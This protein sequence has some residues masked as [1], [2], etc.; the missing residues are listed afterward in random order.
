[1]SQQII[2][3]GAEANDG[4]GEP[5]RSAFN[6]VN[7]N[8]S[9][10]YAAGPVGSNVKITGNTITVTGI[11]NNL[12][13]AANGIGNIQANSSF[14]PS[15]SGVYSLGANGAQFDSVYSV[16]FYGNGA[17]LTGVSVDAGN[18]ILNGNSNV[19]I[20]GENAN[21][22]VS[23]NAVSNIAVFSTSG[24]TVSSNINVGRLNANTISVSG[25]ITS[26]LVSQ[27]NIT[28]N[29]FLGNGSQLTGMYSNTNAQN[30]LPTYTGNLESLQGD[31]T[32]TA[33]ISGGNIR[34]LGTLSVTGTITSGNVT[35]LGRVTA[36]GNVVSNQ[37]F[38]GNGRFLEGV[39]SAPANLY[40]TVNANGTVLTANNTSGVFTL[41]PGNNIVITGND[42]TLAAAFGVSQNPEFTGN[43]SATGNIVSGTNIQATSNISGGNIAATSLIT[44]GN[45]SATG[46][47]NAGNVNAGNVNAGNIAAT[48]RISTTGNVT[49]SAFFGNGIFNSNTS[50]Q[51][52][53][54]NVTVTPAGSA[55]NTNW[56]FIDSGNIV[57]G[58]GYGKIINN[59]S[60]GVSL[61]ATDFA[62]ASLEWSNNGTNQTSN[63][64]AAANIT[65]STNSG[66]SIWKFDSTGNLILPNTMKVASITGNIDTNSAVIIGGTHT[67]I[68]IEQNNKINIVSSNG[69]GNTFTWAFGTAGNLSFPGGATIASG[70]FDAGA[71]S[72][73]VSLRAVSTDGNTV[74]IRAQGNTSSAVIQT[75]ANA[76]ATTNNWTFGVNGVLT[77]AGNINASYFIGNGSQLTGL[78]ESY[79][80]TN[81]STYLAS[82]NNSANI[83]TT[84]NVSGSFLLGNGAAISSVNAISLLGAVPATAAN[85]NSLV[86]R[87]ANGNI[88]GNFYL[89]NAS[90]M[91]GLPVAYSN[92]A[93]AAY[94]PTYT[95]NL[96]SMTGNIVTTANIAGGNVSASGN[97]FRVVSFW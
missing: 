14:I 49:G 93:V 5:L 61:W 36:V 16:A 54:G 62:D 72:A 58:Q 24:L 37:F 69:V 18:V 89:G 38:V 39:I 90:Q 43:V 77:A 41:I 32:T 75:Y 74:S 87:D 81:V 53:S 95:G 96:V 40:S 65:V 46:N 52:N 1:M 88:T 26:N 19:R 73:T 22:T 78:P 47:V 51:L 2:D 3:I 30:F 45:I 92:A 57:L 67:N 59:G 76:T 42:L 82:G 34:S 20:G 94:L 6:A 35:S 86:Q 7:Q 85:A 91:S 48:G 9:E 60:F 79:S 13:L 80:N 64:V 66:A 11:N 97:I 71:P 31:V 27:A 63:V 56:T 10:V 70:V 44:G 25:N 8:F 17:G 68:N 84:A 12:V 50:V 4:T 15:V 55:P 29:Y 83:I 21:V 23:V 33:N 28:A